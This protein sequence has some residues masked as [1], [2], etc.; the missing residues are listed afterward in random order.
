MTDWATIRGEC[1]LWE[2]SGVMALNK[3]AGI[4]VTGERHGDDVVSLAAAAG[5]KL[6]PVHRIDKATSGLV[7]IA[8]DLSLHGDLTRQFNKRTVGKAYLAATRAVGLPDFGVVDLPLS[9]GRKNRVR[10]A[11][12]R[13]TIVNVNGHWSVPDSEVFRYAKT[14]PSTTR[15]A[16]ICQVGDKTV[17]AV[18]P[19]TGRRHQIRIHLAWI[20][21]PIVSDPLFD[22]RGKGRMLLHSWRLSFDAA[23]CDGERINLEAS[24]GGDFW[25]S[26]PTIYPP[27][28]LERASQAM[29]ALA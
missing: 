14:Y 24:P 26:L 17:L 3:P 19:E 2:G 18:R 15:F 25:A 6:Y 12:P 10:V 16:K 20:G 7:L 5:E 4:S 27:E 28:I 1:V 9:T 8:T 22:R 11:A 13:E 21:C 29:A 23:W